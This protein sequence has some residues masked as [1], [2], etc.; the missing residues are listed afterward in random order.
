MDDLSF[1]AQFHRALDPTA[2][3]APW[4]A[5]HVREGLARRRRSVRPGLRG[6]GRLRQP[7]GLLP[8]VAVLLAIA[9]IIAIVLS[10][11]ML[12]FNRSIPVFPPQ[13]GLAGPAG[14]P[15]WSIGSP[16]GPGG[17]GD[18][19]ASVSTGWVSGGLRTTDGGAGWTRVLPDAMLS[20]APAGTDHRAYPPGYT[21]YFLDANHAWLAYALPSATSCFDHVT[22]FATA[23]GGET[24][25]RSHPL[26]AAIQADTGLQLVLDFVDPQHGWLLVLANGRLAPDW[27]V[28]ATANGGVDWRPVS[29]IPLMSSFCSATFVSLQ[30]GFL[31]GCSN[32]SGPSADLTVTRDGGRTWQDVRLP[33]PG[34]GSLSVGQPHFFDANHG[35][36]HVT[37]STTEGNVITPSDLLDATDDGG[38]TWHALPPVEVTGYSQAFAFAD[39]THFYDLVGA[40]KG[41]SD[42]VYRSLDGGMT[43]SPVNESTDAYFMGYSQLLFVD[44]N[45]GFI[46]EP[47]Q[48]FGQAPHTFLATSDGGRTWKDMH[49]R[50]T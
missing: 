25:K 23:D 18:R 1:R 29:Q 47:G 33:A 22:V 19:M 46:D 16:G 49:P 2:P 11:R 43:W 24:W 15:G 36:V 39:P 27:F 4:L 32:A 44:S 37:V 48:Q 8:A 30:V 40:P 34:E 28:Y 9:I 5:A 6:S 31:G 42:S 14:C 7:P 45:H 21:D 38:Q 13:H 3:A 12:P 17:G 41:G 50:L 10:S 20:D 26:E 35:V